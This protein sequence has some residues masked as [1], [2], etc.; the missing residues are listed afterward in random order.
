MEG[1]KSLISQINLISF[2]NSLGIFFQ[3][4]YLQVIMQGIRA[5][6]SALLP[7]V[8]SGAA[9][10]I[11]DA[12]P[13]HKNRPKLAHSFD[14]RAKNLFRADSDKRRWTDFTKVLHNYGQGGYS[15][16]IIILFCS[17][18][19]CGYGMYTKFFYYLHYL[20]YFIFTFD[21]DYRHILGPFRSSRGR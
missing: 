5:V 17:Y 21:M 15:R 18:T 6:F 16:I 20:K 1:I 3:L 14:F 8:Y 11:L 10:I 9:A 13:V 2:F 12:H 19:R 4:L 7:N